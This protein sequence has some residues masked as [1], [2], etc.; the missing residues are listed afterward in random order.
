MQLTK[1]QLKK[2][3]LEEI[4]DLDEQQIDPNKTDPAYKAIYKGYGGIMNI[5][6]SPE[7]WTK[8]TGIQDDNLRSTM[9]KVFEPHTKNIMQGLDILY[10]RAQKGTKP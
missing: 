10:H 7:E 9:N 8:H 5:L 4:E 6:Y 2:L 1:Q 3:I